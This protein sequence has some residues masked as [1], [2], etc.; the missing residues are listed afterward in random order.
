[1]LSIQQKLWSNPSYREAAFDQLSKILNEENWLN[2]ATSPSLDLDKD[3][4]SQEKHSIFDQH[5]E[6]VS[7]LFGTPDNAFA[8]QLS[9]QRLNELSNWLEGVS[10]TTYAKAQRRSS[11]TLYVKTLQQA[12]AIE[13]LDNNIILFDF[14]MCDELERLHREIRSNIAQY[15]K[16]PFIFINTRAWT[17]KSQSEKFGPN[18]PHK[19]GFHK[20]HMKIMVY[21]TPMSSEYG[22]FWIEGHQITDNEPGFCLSFKNSDLLH[23]GQPG[24]KFPRICIEVTIM[25]AL[26]DGSQDDEPHPL[27][28]HFL[29]VGSAYSDECYEQKLNR[30]NGDQFADDFQVIRCEQTI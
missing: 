22:D 4:E 1:M 8:F 28:R 21:L 2:N 18:A 6:L 14:Q 24:T 9:V 15:V 25:R 27:G 3:M 10:T 5:D 29:N 7:H 17:T 30:I 23:S 12:N 20:G 16:S 19:D 11:E 26:H 13:K